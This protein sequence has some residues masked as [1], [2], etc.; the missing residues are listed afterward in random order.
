MSDRNPAQRTEPKGGAP[1]QVKVKDARSMSRP[2]APVRHPTSGRFR[3]KQG[4]R[5]GQ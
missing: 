5:R 4:G 3:A 2:A 1:V